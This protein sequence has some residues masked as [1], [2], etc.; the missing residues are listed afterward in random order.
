MVQTE[1][2][3]GEEHGY[4]SEMVELIEALQAQIKWR[5]YWYNNMYYKRVQSSEEMSLTARNNDLF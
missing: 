5:K 4:F 1:R 3:M 2:T